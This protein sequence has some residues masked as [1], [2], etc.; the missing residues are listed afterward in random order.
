MVLEYFDEN[1]NDL[2][3]YIVATELQQGW[4]RILIKCGCSEIDKCNFLVRIT[5][6]HG[7]PVEGL[8]VS[9]EAQSY[10]HRP[11][12]PL[13]LLENSFESFFKTQ[14]K[15]Y[16]DRAE[17][18][19]LLAQLYLRDDKAP[20]AEHILRSA[21]K[22]WS[23]CP[24]FYTLLME[25]YQRGTKQDEI[26]EL[27]VKLSAINS[28]LPEVLS[29]RL[30][31]ALRNEEYQKSEELLGQL[32]T[33]RY[34]PEYVYQ[35]EIELLGKRKEID[36]LVALV[37]VAHTT[38]PLNWNFAN[39]QALIESEIHHDPE[40]AAGV[41]K[42]YL[43][44]NYG[45]IHLS[46]MAAYYLKAG[47]VDKWEET[48]NEA[49][50]LAPTTTGYFYSMGLVYQLAESYPKAEIEFRRALA[51]CPSGS[52]YWSKL[53]EVYKSTGRT[54]EAKAAYG[55][56]LKFDPR[57]FA[58]REAL[59]A[60]EGK[61]PIFSSFSSFSIDSLI[62]SAP[63][64]KDYENDDGVILLDDTKRV[65]FEQGASMIV[66]E[67]LVKEF[68][69]RGIDAWKE[70]S[71]NYNRYNEALIVEKAV[72]IK[73]DGTE[74]KADVNN[75]DVVFKS[76]EPNDCIYLKWKVKNYYSGML[77]KHF[78]DTHYF[79]G[80]FPIRI[81]RYSLMVP[82]DVHFTHQTQLTMDAP[83]IRRSDEGVMYEWQLKNEPAVR[84]EQG[85]PVFQD[86][87]KMLYVSTIPSWEYIASWYSDVA[88]TKT[89]ATFEIKDQV[90][91]LFDG[92]PAMRDE[93]KV[94]VIYDFITE[95]IHYSSISFR[96]S[97]LVPQRARDVLVQRMGD[98]KDMATLC[99]A[100]LNEVGIKAH[101]VLV[102]TWDEGYNRN[103]PP[104]IAFNHCIVGVELKSGVRHIDLTASNFPIG[105]I[106]PVVNG[107]FALAI[108]ESTRMPMHLAQEQFLSNNL[109]RT[110]TASLN[111]DNSMMF[112]CSSRRTGG[113]SAT[114]RSRYRN[115]SKAECIKSLT[116]M[117]SNDYPNIQVKDISVKDIDSLDSV[118]ED[119][120]EYRVPQFVSE[121][122]GF[123]LVRMPWTDKLVPAEALSYE[124]RMYPY[125][126]WTGN[127]TLRQ[128]LRLKFPLG[129]TLQE[130]P[131]ARTL[132]NSAG[133]YSV[134][135]KKSAGE[136][137][138]T[139]ML[140]YKKSDVNPDEYLEYKKFY[141][142]ALKEDN[143]QLLLKKTK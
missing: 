110:S 33:Q 109:V 77:A 117:L 97:A 50:D 54:E 5:D 114:V 9:T 37:A 86:V 27:L 93:E 118:I 85:M 70:Y 112:V 1:N 67:L 75:G 102:N 7:D 107:A 57:D 120:Q 52:V 3:T 137:L 119:S 123:K 60:L 142:E 80:F 68:S 25:T 91:S 65:L 139:R 15:L 73:R 63:G 45:L 143:R 69:A 134:E 87:A 59:R 55:C 96:Q 18:Y 98:C 26:E 116:E 24:L 95:N 126:L 132:S 41:V 113:A 72:T 99:I 17:N 66:S 48:M 6:E 89:R 130:V 138:G 71:I 61:Q 14:I 62:R 23:R 39:L 81:S 78:W 58:S 16:P 10:P 108:E 101:Y 31:E 28:Q 43:A 51:L 92:K 44:K 13:T 111:D 35:M 79:N 32:K 135:Y 133:T 34:N 104:G 38:F 12:A 4:N 2:D 129:Y 103:V 64:K 128:S 8:R 36:K 100:M 40:K 136:L 115:K 94:K 106:P 42:A 29:Y 46:A 125:I 53:A 141:N 49:V 121:A 30:G 19:A 47:K 74:V 84:Y 131:R 105:S 21:L 22:Q 11:S 90:A 140:V 124:S 76:L 127:D 56:A 20:Q 82:K 88:R 83:V 122:G